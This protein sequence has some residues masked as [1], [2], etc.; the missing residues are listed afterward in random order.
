MPTGVSL[1][2]T[3]VSLMPTGVSLMPTGV[4]LMRP[5]TSLVPASAQS[6]RTPHPFA[7]SPACYPIPR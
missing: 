4:S 7:T 3:G 1:M 6:R 2:P 5:G